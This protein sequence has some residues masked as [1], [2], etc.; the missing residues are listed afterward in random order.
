M[1]VCA[2]FD[3]AVTNST[4]GPERYNLLNIGWTHQEV[5]KKKKKEK[6][7]ERERGGRQHMRNDAMQVAEPHVGL[8]RAKNATALICYH[9]LWIDT[10]TCGL[11]K[12][13]I[14]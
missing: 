8:I 11:C 14:V 10:C 6:E 13:G 5:E 1:F 3:D 2:S 4:R 7:K 9:N 12:S